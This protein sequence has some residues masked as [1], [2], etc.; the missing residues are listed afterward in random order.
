MGTNPGRTGDRLLDLAVAG[1]RVVVVGSAGFSSAVG[2]GGFAIV[3][4]PRG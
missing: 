3:W 1:D 2:V 4:S